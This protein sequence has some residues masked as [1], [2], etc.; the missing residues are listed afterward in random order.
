MADA[1]K[2]ASSPSTSTGTKPK[3]SIKKILLYVVIG[4][5]ALFLI[6]V[7]FVNSATKE[8][9]AVSNRFVDSIQASQPAA[10]YELFS[11]DAKRTVT[12]EE[13]ATIVEQVGPILNTTEK[14]T[15]KEIAG[16]TGQSSIAKV[17]YEI[18]GSDNK[19]Y[20]FIVNLVKENDVWK[21]LNFDSKLK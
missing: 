11:T 13:F 19:T 6:L 12:A 3:R 10:A 14:I 8:P 7:L 15:G 1:E 16:E 9:V 4:V 18:A 5:V 2:P 20:E 21:V 17:T